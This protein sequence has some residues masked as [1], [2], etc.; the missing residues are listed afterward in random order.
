MAIVW[1]R[2]AGVGAC[3]FPHRIGQDTRCPPERPTRSPGGRNPFEPPTQP[4]R[5]FPP[6]CPNA[7]SKSHRIHP[8]AL[9]LC[10]RL[11]QL[12][13]S[14]AR[15]TI[16]VSESSSKCRIQSKSSKQGK[17]LRVNLASP[18]S[19]PPG[20][21]GPTCMIRS[22]W[23]PSRPI[24]PFSLDAGERARSH[25]PEFPPRCRTFDLPAS[26]GW[27]SDPASWLAGCDARFPRHPQRVHDARPPWM[28]LRLPKPADFG[29]LEAAFAESQRRRS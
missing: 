13:C 4:P 22:K 21:V 28:T 29:P 2:L 5:A 24:R 27:R 16:L 8:S 15:K 3:Q 9:P 1:E 14:S 11:I 17:N 12:E 26:P 20:Q 25:R 10:G 19:N 18:C 7:I 6:G 23:T